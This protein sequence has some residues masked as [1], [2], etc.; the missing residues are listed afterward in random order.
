M[1][2][3]SHIKKS[4][5]TALCMALCV[6]LPLAFHA[7]PDGG[8]IYSPMHIPVLLCGLICGA[9]FGLF[10]G[11]TGPL[12]SSLITQMPPMAYLPPMMIELASYG[13]ISGLVLQVVHTGKRTADLYISLIIAMMS[14]RVISGIVKA[15]I[16]SAG[17]YSIAM[18]V[19][20]YFVTS[21]PGMIIQLILIPILVLALE[22][23][24]LIPMCRKKQTA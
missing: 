13:C 20:G 9:P 21:L 22:K 1:R 17:H 14:G 4:V 11:L 16:F 23:S 3:M 19:T 6:V 7:I 24:H 8:T 12:L 10:C 18:W 5:I 15:L 2:K